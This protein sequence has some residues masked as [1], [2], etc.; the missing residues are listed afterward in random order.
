MI[1]RIQS[2]W[3]LLSAIGFGLNFVPSLFLLKTKT[4]GE[5]VL[6]DQMVQVT[7]HNLTLIGS[8]A[9]IVLILI[10][11]FLY[12][13]RPLQLIVSNLGSICFIVTALGG[14][15]WL[16]QSQGKFEEI[17]PGIGFFSGFLGIICI[18]LATRAIKND[19]KLVK[20]MDRLR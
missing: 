13:N 3:L 11:I 8:I 10:A 12:A 4:A 14:A 7:E 15:A 16:C 5:G 19:E 17:T 1:Q 20:S 18:W 2:I 9:A 6:A